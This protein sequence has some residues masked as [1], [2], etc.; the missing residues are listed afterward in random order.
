[1]IGNL[2]GWNM[3]K[4]VYLI[5]CWCWF[6]LNYKKIPRFLRRNLPKFVCKLSEVTYKRKSAKAG[7]KTSVVQRL[8]ARVNHQFGGFFA[9][10]GVYTGDFSAD[11]SCKGHTVPPG[12]SRAAHQGASQYGDFKRH[13][14]DPKFEPCH[15][16]SLWLLVCMHNHTLAFMSYSFTV[17]L[18]CISSTYIQSILSNAVPKGIVST[19]NLE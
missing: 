11:G 2:I 1:V 15:I 12:L 19:T 7:S 8:Q 16:S 4:L 10:H 9:N 6:L 17:L 18:W 14:S 13:A 3:G 5:E